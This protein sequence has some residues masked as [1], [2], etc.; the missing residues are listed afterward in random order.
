M[1]VF[2]VHFHSEQ[3]FNSGV[4]T[5]DCGEKYFLNRETAERAALNW[6]RKFYNPDEMVDMCE[7]YGVATWEEVE[8]R[9]TRRDGA[10][11]YTLDFSEI[12]EIEIDES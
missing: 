5:I 8:E 2:K 7:M 3:N 11:Y 6:E 1:K 4:K 12:T 10:P 9:M